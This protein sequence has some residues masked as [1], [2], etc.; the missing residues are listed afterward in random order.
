MPIVPAILKSPDAEVITYA[1]LDNCSTGTF[2]L[3]DLLEDLKIDGVS[4]H[5]LVRTMNGQQRHDVKVLKGLTVTD[6]DG[7]NSVV[8]SKVFTKN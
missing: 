3:Q 2:V 4:S 7:N 8:L 6:L 1:M 5:V